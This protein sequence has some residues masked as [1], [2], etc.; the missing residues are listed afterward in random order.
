MHKGSA[1]E[2]FVIMIMCQ[3]CRIHR[4]LVEAGLGLRRLRTYSRLDVQRD[5]GCSP[6]TW[7][8]AV[9]RQVHLCCMAALLVYVRSWL[10][11]MCC[12]VVCVT[13][14]AL[15]SLTCS[16]RRQCSSEHAP[17]LVPE[18]R[19]LFLHQSS[20]QGI[21]HCLSALVTCSS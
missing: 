8:S 5:M 15:L 18:Q 11:E 20:M 12:L 10:G 16:Y 2:P 21:L 17:V 14:K 19:S 6:Y 3:L 1:T 9:T 13:Q 4:C 7:T